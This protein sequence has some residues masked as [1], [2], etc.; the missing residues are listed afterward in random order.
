MIT[1]TDTGTVA[2]F[3]LALIF[4]SMILGG[5]AALA[6][7]VAFF[8]STWW[9][10]DY[11][12]NLRWYLLWIL[13][14]SAVVYALSAKGWMLIILVAALIANAVVMLPLWTGSQPEST[15]EDSLAIVHLDAS[16]GFS[17]R[18]QA[19]DWLRESDADLLLISS[20]TSTIVEQVAQID[21]DWM[22]LLEPEIENTAGMIVL[23]RTAWEVAVTPTG[24][25]TDT[26]VRITTDSA[27]RVYEIVT[28]AG[29]TAASSSDAERLSARLDT[30]RAITASATHPVVVV[31]NLGAT[32]WTYGM[33]DLL[34][35]TDLRD[36]TEGKGYLSTT[37]A[38]RF[39][40]IGGWLGLPLDVVLMTSTIT[41]IDLKTGPD[42]SA[43]QLPVSF[44]V[45]PTA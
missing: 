13:L 15:G 20:G 4:G 16:G 5:L 14:V 45:G 11:L 9:V 2:G 35:N 44:T 10:F 34:S 12:A 1:W 25:G 29:P 8:G 21:T 3:R 6:T 26:V 23:A 36:A 42:I 31:G 37:N 32:R 22:V 43:G 7:V 17:N 41:P 38:S 30:I 19:T 39:P 33:R 28:A 27:G 24:V 18:N 40:V